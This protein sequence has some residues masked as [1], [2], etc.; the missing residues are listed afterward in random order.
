MV[1]YRNAACLVLV[2]L[3]L[4][5]QFGTAPVRGELNTIRLLNRLESKPVLQWSVSDVVQWMNHT[6]GYAEYSNYI[7]KHLI[8][9]PTLLEMEPADF[10]SF[11]PITS[12]LHVIKIQAH[13]KLLRGQCSCHNTT[14]IT[15]KRD[16]WAYM[17]RHS[18]RTWVEG[19]TALYFSRVAML[20]TYLFDHDFYIDIIR[21][22]GKLEDKDGAMED[23]AVNSQGG[24]AG[25]R[26]RKFVYWV[27]WIFAPDLYL[28]YHSARLCA[29][30]YFLMPLM[31]IHFITQACNEYFLIYS[32]YHKTAFTPGTS[33]LERIWSLYAYT[34]FVPVVGLVVGYVF[35]V[36]LQII[37]LLV[38]VIHN[39]I[40][41][42]GM[43]MLIFIKGSVKT[44]QDNDK[45]KDT[46]EAKVDTHTN[47]NVT[48]DR[49]IESNKKID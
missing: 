47:T 45:D 36:I 46:H 38:L 32:I 12:P 9:G 48:D 10:E 35:P 43:F 37:C 39:L 13:I 11:F 8:D 4:L 6:I 25:L 27:S 44:P 41:L 3:F 26:F 42:F 30:N 22:G 16:F 1:C 7:R 14:T 24:G 49:N 18:V 28:A 21:A 23:A 40:I 31:L 2:A 33:T 34:I 17:K 19:T 5:A 20:T 29:V 15:G